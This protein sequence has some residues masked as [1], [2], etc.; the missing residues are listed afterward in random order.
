[1]PAQIEN[2]RDRLSKLSITAEKPKLPISGEDLKAAGIK[3][4][5]VYS[6]IMSAV[7][8]LWYENPSLSKE[9]SLKVATE[10]SKKV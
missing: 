5:P 10:L 4:G 6:E 9:E 2:I 8:E 1:M 3:P 7:L